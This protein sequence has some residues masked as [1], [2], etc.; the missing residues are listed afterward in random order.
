MT[1]QISTQVPDGRGLGHRLRDGNTAVL[2]DMLDF[3]GKLP[4][5]VPAD[6]TNT[7]ERMSNLV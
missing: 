2:A 7:P 6:E 3:E 1:T 4:I 5:S